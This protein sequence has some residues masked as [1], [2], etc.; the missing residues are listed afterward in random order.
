MEDYKERLV[1]EQNDLKEKFIKLVKFI[2]SEE[3][4]KL[5]NNNK[6]VLKNQKIIMELYL[7]VLNMRI[8]EDIDN[9]VVPDLGFMQ[10]MGSMF[11]ST[12]N[13]PKNFPKID[14]NTYESTVKESEVNT[15][16]DNDKDMK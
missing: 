2:N 12:F 1:K 8:Y 16:I 13:F 10:M 5:S 7:S 6:Q 3:F 15:V 4:F 9:I 11:G 14:N